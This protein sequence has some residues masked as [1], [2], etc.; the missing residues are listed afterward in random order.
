MMGRDCPSRPARV[1]VGVDALNPIIDAHSSNLLVCG[2][3]A[4]RTSAR[5]GSPVFS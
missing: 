1:I 5:S 4:G 2:T 3:M